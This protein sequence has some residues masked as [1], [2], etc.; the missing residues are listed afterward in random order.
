MDT[1]DILVKLRTS[2]MRNVMLQIIIRSHLTLSE[3]SLEKN[4]SESGLC[5]HEQAR[6]GP[7]APLT[8][9][10][11]ADVLLGLHAGPPTTGAGVVPDSIASVGEDVP[12][13]AVTS[14]ARISWMG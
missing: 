13:P 11:V 3:G 5:L 4:G 2:R 12:S 14:Y 6:A 10:Y 8:P 7:S 9:T 1:G